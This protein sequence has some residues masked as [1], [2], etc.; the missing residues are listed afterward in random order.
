MDAS[1]P[2]YSIETF[3]EAVYRAILSRPPHEDG[4]LNSIRRLV[5]LGTNAT[6]LT[7]FIKGFLASQEY[8]EKAT[9]QFAQRLMANSALANGERIDFVSLGSH[10]LVSYALKE[11][12]LKRYSCPFDWIFSQPSM[13]EHCIK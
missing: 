8:Q 12:G 13:V 9:R 10:C 3:V 11:M 1:E 7:T 2:R 6:D 4:L 5:S